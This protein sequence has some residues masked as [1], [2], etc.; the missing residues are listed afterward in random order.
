MRHEVQKC[1]KSINTGK[2]PGSDGIYVESLLHSGD[3]V[4]DQLYKLICDVWNGSPVPQD[5]VDAILVSLYKG[6]S[7]KTEW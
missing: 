6:K 4:F 7:A 2:A 5:W 3:K 1:L